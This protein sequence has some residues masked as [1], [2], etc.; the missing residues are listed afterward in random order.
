M[1]AL[2]RAIKTFCQTCLGFFT[3][4]VA[5]SDIQWSTMLSVAA[6]AAI[7]SLFT[8]IVGGI[9]EVNTDGTLIIKDTVPN[10]AAVWQFQVDT[11]LDEIEKAS[12]IRLRVENYS[13]TS[14]S[15]SNGKS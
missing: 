7:Y 11:P 13:N 5:L 3:I 12:T 4:G 1:A 8:S 14:R 15:E 2:I 9:P 6:V 10:E